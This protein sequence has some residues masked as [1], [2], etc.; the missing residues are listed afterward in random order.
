VFLDLWAAG[1]ESGWARVQVI[2][3]SWSEVLS[4]HWVSLACALGAWSLL[5]SWPTA[6]G[7]DRLGR[8]LLALGLVCFWLGLA[9]AAW[10]CRDFLGKLPLVLVPTFMPFDALEPSRARLARGVLVAGV[11]LVLGASLVACALWRAPERAAPR[12]RWLETL[13]VVLLGGAAALGLERLGTRFAWE[14]AHPIDTSF[15][16]ANCGLCM[17]EA[18]GLEGRGPHEFAEGPHVVLT[19]PHWTVDGGRVGQDQLFNVLKSKREL[20]RQINMGREFPG[21]VVFSARSLG[22]VAQLEAALNAALRAGYPNVYLAFTEVLRQERPVLGTLGGRR[23]TAL[24]L[25]LARGLSDCPAPY[26]RA[27]HLGVEARASGTSWLNQLGRVKGNSCVLLPAWQT[28][29]RYRHGVIEAEIEVIEQWSLGKRVEAAKLRRDHAEYLVAFVAP[30]SAISVELMN[31]PKDPWDGFE[32]LEA[33]T[34]RKGQK[35][36]WAMNAGMYHSDRSPVGLFVSHSE[37]RTALNTRSGKG[38]F[39][40]TPNGVFEVTDSGSPVVSSTSVWEGDIY[41]GPPKQATQSGPMLVI[42]GEL[43]PAFE[44]DSP[45]RLIRNGIGVA[46]DPPTVVMAISNTRVNFYEFAALMR[47]LGCHNALYLDGNVSSVF[48]PG[49]GRRDAGLRLGPVI[50]VREVSD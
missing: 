20:W 22:A 44:R 13:S 9:F 5:V 37:E 15:A 36:V 11:S 38:N 2:A 16:F 25:F 28:D 3:L 50:V 45:S 1:F 42:N 6:L 48:A 24:R 43:H 40:L 14:N 23:D 49:A 34:R 19:P 46:H 10:S 35:L 8:R 30:E 33:R 39:F 26:A 31:D 21:N 4:A 41:A 12:W 27:V 17:P 32:A 47:D 29:I 18:L 7:L